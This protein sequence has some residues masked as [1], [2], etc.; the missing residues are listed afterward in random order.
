[1]RSWVWWH[2]P[3]ILAL[4]RQRRV[5]AYDYRLIWVYIS[6]SQLVGQDPFRG[7]I[8]DICIMIHNSKITSVK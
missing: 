4:G 1:M 8:S 6:G 2:I 5:D 7:C 3:L